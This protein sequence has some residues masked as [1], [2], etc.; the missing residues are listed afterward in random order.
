MQ[1]P[2]G[3]RP[4]AHQRHLARD[5]MPQLRQFVDRVPPKELWKPAG[6][7]GIVL[8]LALR[9]AIVGDVFHPPIPP[10]SAAA[11]SATVPHGAQLQHP[12]RCAMPPDAPVRNQRSPSGQN[13]D[14]AGARQSRRQRQNQKRKSRG[15]FKKT[16]DPPAG[17]V[18]GNGSTVDRNR[19]QC[20]TWIDL[21]RSCVAS[22]PERVNML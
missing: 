22:V 20:G 13:A 10:A 16:D 19:S 6:H 9:P 11:P 2:L 21:T 17:T 3:N 12:Q 5:H 8:Q 4:R 1:F 7:A 15:P 14:Q 18:F